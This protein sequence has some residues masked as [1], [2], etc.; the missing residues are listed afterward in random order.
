MKLLRKL[1]KLLIQQMQFQTF[2]STW[3]IKQKRIQHPDF[4][5]KHSKNR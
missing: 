3:I 1:M 4:N 2:K 5:L